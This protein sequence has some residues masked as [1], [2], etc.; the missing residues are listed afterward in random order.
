[1]KSENH[2]AEA[3]I[4]KSPKNSSADSALRILIVEGDEGD[5]TLIRDY[6]ND[7]SDYSF[8]IDW[9][10]NYDEGFKAITSFI[11]DIY[12]ID[13]FLGKKTGIDLLREAIQH[14]CRAP[15][16]L[17]TGQIHQKIDIE[18]IRSGAADYL[19]K[20]ELNTEKLDR[21]IRY[22]LERST[23]LKESKATERKFRTIFEH[24]KDVIFLSDDEL[25]M[26]EVNVA[27][28]T[29]FGYTTAE[30]LK[31]T[32]Y[33]LMPSP[34]E[35]DELKRKLKRHKEI[36]DFQVGFLTKNKLRK[37][38]MLSTS[39][40]TDSTGQSYIQGII[41]DISVL[42]K[43]E[44]IRVQSEKLEAKGVVIRTLAHEIRNPLHNINLSLGFLKTEIDDSKVEFLNVIE[45]NSNRINDL[46]NQ[47]MDS[48]QYYKLKL[49]VVPLQEVMKETLE[50]A[51]DQIVLSNIKLNLQLPKKEARALVDREKLKIAFL[52]VI[53]N[54]IE[55]MSK[56]KGE[57]TISISSDQDF[58]TVAIKDNGCGMSEESAKKVF[59]PYFTSKPNGLGLG[60]AATFAIVQ[61]HKAEIEVLSAINEGTTFTFTFP[62]L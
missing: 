34:E 27:A 45:R 29:I 12:F 9:C 22:S 56:E 13:Y 51:E 21:C 44:E 28:T 40:E 23:N 31:L 30:L 6:I 17:L 11:H 49:E 26:K 60:L 3:S 50:K 38:C 8:K 10:G 25:R 47:L 57:L 5:Y 4:P 55:A 14:Q 2:L 43:V 24:S 61:S 1:M 36:I 20:S 46:I 52:N 35:K 62:S 58:H 7:I 39:F 33:D 16:I 59:E 41:Q 15:I 19:I 42:K 37:N 53:V 54:A 48:N 18:A 32:I